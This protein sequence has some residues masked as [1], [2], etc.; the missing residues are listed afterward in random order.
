[1]TFTTRLLTSLRVSPSLSITGFI[2]VIAPFQEFQQ[3]LFAQH[4]LF[5]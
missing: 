4:S 3:V 1:M 2:S 5:E